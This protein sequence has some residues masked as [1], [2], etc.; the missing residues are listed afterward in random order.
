MQ[1]SCAY[2]LPNSALQDSCA[3]QC[4]GAYKLPYSASVQGGIVDVVFQFPEAMWATSTLTACTTCNT[5]GF[6]DSS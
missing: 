1:C 6:L 5:A 4:Y 3:M 2:K